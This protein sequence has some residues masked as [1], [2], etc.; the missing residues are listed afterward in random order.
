MTKFYKEYLGG[1]YYFSKIFS[2]IISYVYN[3]ESFFKKRTLKYDLFSNCKNS[4]LL[5][6]KRNVNVTKRK[7]IVVHFPTSEICY[8]YY[9]YFL[10]ILIPQFTFLNNYEKKKII[11]N[12]YLISNQINDSATTHIY[13]KI[14]AEEFNIIFCSSILPREKY[15]YINNLT[16][17]LE[18]KYFLDLY[19]KETHLNNGQ[20]KESKQQCSYNIRHNKGRKE[21]GHKNSRKN[22]LTFFNPNGI[23]RFCNNFLY[24]SYISNNNFKQNKIA[25]VRRKNIFNSFIKYNTIVENIN[26]KIHWI[27]HY[28]FY[29]FY[30]KAYLSFVNY[31]MTILQ[32]IVDTHFEKLRK[33]ENKKVCLKKNKHTNILRLFLKY[34]DVLLNSSIFFNFAKQII[35]LDFKDAASLY[36]KYLEALEKTSVLVNKQNSISLSLPINNDD[37]NCGDNICRYNK[38]MLIKEIQKCI[39]IHIWNNNQ[40][41]LF[42]S[43]LKNIKF[44]KFYN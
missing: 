7:N 3:K 26:S 32:N 42:Y 28:S 24:V 13:N 44:R 36:I 34:K 39:N 38:K 16:L 29:E 10:Y 8:F 6:R 14:K 5:K 4:L 11:N 25:I 27:N 17:F 21:Y 30:S 41:T 19:N 33:S 18:N 2:Y 43:G 9:H 12:I 20:R 35:Y 37:K 31:R 15:D 23:N 22:N 40:K 1:D